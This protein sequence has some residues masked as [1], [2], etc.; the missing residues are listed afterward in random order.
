MSRIVTGYD[1][2][3]ID[4][5]KAFGIDHKGVRSATI[6]I[7]ADA[8][9]TIDIKKYVTL[10]GG[11]EFLKLVQEQYTFEPKKIK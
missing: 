9:T 11:E 5:L 4:V 3:G 8:I 2:F 7:D 6:K 10:E 1:S